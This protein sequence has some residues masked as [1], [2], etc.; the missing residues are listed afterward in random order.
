[1]F[2]LNFRLEIDL[3]AFGR[4]FRIPPTQLQELQNT[5]NK[6]QRLIFTDQFDNYN[7]KIDFLY[8]LSFD[9]PKDIL[10][11]EEFNVLLY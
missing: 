4:R 3:F 10:N 7:K 8:E 1:M 6:E 9:N 11:I 5:L 2:V